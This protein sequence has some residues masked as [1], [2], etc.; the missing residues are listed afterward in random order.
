MTEKA[1]LQA[2]LDL[3]HRPAYRFS[4]LAALSTRAMAGMLA[5][6]F[7]ITVAGWKALS[8]IGAFGPISSG[9]VARRSSMDPDKVTRAVDQLVDKGLVAR[10]VDREDRRRVVLTLTA[11]GKRAYGE[12]DGMRRQVD[13]QFLSVLSE[14]ERRNL[15]AALDKL[16][17]QARRIFN[18]RDAWK[19]LVDAG[20]KRRAK[21]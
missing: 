3:E 7:S 14:T 20:R 4:I 8:M 9:S 10:K 16:E 12:I 2:Q 17:L 6:R 11:R 1:P 19:G 13:V 21:A 5:E 18:G 15:F